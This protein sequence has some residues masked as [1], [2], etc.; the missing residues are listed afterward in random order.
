[1]DTMFRPVGASQH[2]SVGYPGLAPWAK[3]CRPFGAKTIPY[4]HSA[5]GYLT[6]RRAGGSTVMGKWLGPALTSNSS[7][8]V[9]NRVKR[10]SIRGALLRGSSSARPSVGGFTSTPYRPPS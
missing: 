10:G 5:T 9:S 4:P 8:D 2:V 7:P 3:L 1:G 6:Y